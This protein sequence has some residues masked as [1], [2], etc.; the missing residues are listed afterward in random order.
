MC[1]NEPG[2][3]FGCHTAGAGIA[4]GSIYTCF[5][6]CYLVLILLTYAKDIKSVLLAAYQLGMVESE[7]FAFI[8]IDT[9]EVVD[10]VVSILIA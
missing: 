6:S 5:L 8:T 4:Y 9:R 2:L 1:Q 3:L 10:V 7:D